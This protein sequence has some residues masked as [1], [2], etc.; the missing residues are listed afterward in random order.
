LRSWFAQ[1]YPGSMQILFGVAAADDPVCSVVEE[2]IAEFPQIDAR[3]IVC[4]P[5]TGANLKVS[6]LA[7]LEQETIHDIFVISD[8][9]VKVPSDVLANAAGL[10]QSADVGLVNCF[11]RLAN[12]ATAAMRWEGIA[13]NADFWSQVLQSQS[14]KPLDFALGAVMLLRRTD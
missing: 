1:A 9:D 11:Y 5:L 7:Q 2:L 10:L 6:K 3:L 8:A 14:L 12:P 13:I 4:D